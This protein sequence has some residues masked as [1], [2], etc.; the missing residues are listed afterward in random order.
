M[1]RQAYAIIYYVLIL[2]L[3]LAPAK[4]LKA[5]SY[6]HTSEL[7]HCVSGHVWIDEDKD[8]QQQD[9]EKDLIDVL[10]HLYD[11]TAN[12][13]DTTLTDAEGNFLFENLGAREYMVEII[14]PFGYEFLD[15]HFNR[16][17]PIQITVE[18]TQ[19]VGMNEGIQ[20]AMI[21][22]ENAVSVTNIQLEPFYVSGQPFSLKL[23]WVTDKEIDTEGF[24]ILR[25]TTGKYED[26]I[27]VNSDLIL[28][29]GSGE[30]EYYD[31]TILP[32][33]DVFYSYWLSEIENSGQTADYGPVH[34]D[35]DIAQY[36]IYGYFLPLV[37]K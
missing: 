5:Y 3:F 2:F 19:C 14:H 13:I 28:A 22:S 26:A 12:K 18:A 9:N 11:F 34:R 23:R 10:I 31:K 16:P 6:S 17:G 21:L 24:D 33:E 25:S 4:N 32:V 7:D 36:N 30:Y 15:T 20:A 37:M 35:I 27:K 8:G 29:K 1:N